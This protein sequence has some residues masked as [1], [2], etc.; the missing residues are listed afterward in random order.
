M[1]HN[2][3]ELRLYLE[4]TSAGTSKTTYHPFDLPGRYNVI[5]AKLT[6]N[7]DVTAHA[8]NY[9]V[10]TVSNVTQSKTIGTWS[11]ASAGNGTLTG[12]TPVSI[13]STDPLATVVSAGDTLSF[14]K[15]DAASGVAF[16]G[17]VVL[18][19]EHAPL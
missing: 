10:L 13:K 12:G 19:L 8:S 4:T 2:R 14:A 9:T 17:S 7:A 6:A 16:G 5:G 3:T 1:R 11:T 15:A 18:L